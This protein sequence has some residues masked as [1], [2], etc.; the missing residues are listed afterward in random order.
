VVTTSVPGTTDPAILYIDRNGPYPHLTDRW[1]DRERDARLY[2]GP[3]PI[4]AHPPCGPWGS[5]RHLCTKQD[6]DLALRAVEQLVRWGGVL[7]H[8]ANSLLWA[9]LDLPR[10]GD[11]P[12]NGLWTLE[13]EQVR[14]GHPALKRTWLLFSWVAPCD[15]PPIPAWREPT[16]HIDSSTA[17][18]RRGAPVRH[19]PKSQRHLTPPAFARWLIA[20]AS[21]AQVP[22]EQAA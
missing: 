9:E 14:W 17:K 6:P 1:F 16:H 8:P 7:E 15:L 3:F 2:E 20:A 11:F 5:L 19:L 13:V 12:R 21:K 10:P 4:V 18:K 22:K